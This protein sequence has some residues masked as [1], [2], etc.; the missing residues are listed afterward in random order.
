MAE[1]AFS[2]SQG[3][4]GMGIAAILLDML[5]LAARDNDIDGLVAYTS[6]KNK[7][8]RNLFHKLPYKIISKK[9]PEDSEIIVLKALFADPIQDGESPAD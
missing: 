8:M 7:A 5:T 3:Y 4:Q 2:V 1:I 9:D 6:P